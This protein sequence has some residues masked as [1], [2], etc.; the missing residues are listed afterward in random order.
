LNGTA[1]AKQVDMPCGADFRK[2]P[3][4][5]TTSTST[6]WVVA[7]AGDL[8]CPGAGCTLIRRNAGARLSPS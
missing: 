3:E 7:Q 5:V 8:G 4:L 2:L 6:V 1:A